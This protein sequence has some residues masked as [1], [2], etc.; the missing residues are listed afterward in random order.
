MKEVKTSPLATERSIGRKKVRGGLSL[1]ATEPRKPGRNRVYLC[2]MVGIEETALLE[3]GGREPPTED[4]M[5]EVN[6]GSSDSPRLILIS[7]SLSEKE[8]IAYTDLLNE[9]KYVYRMELRG[10]ARLG[11]ISSVPP[12]EHT[13]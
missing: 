8:K 13:T 11:P 6:L 12:T 1:Q 4:Q 5:G 10:N 3:E 7:K 9:F 2:N